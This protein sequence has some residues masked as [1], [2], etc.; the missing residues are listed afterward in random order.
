[1][2]QEETIAYIKEALDKANPFVIQQ[3]YEFILENEEELYV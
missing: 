2:N 1:M 3:I